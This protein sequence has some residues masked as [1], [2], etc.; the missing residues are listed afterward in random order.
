MYLNLKRSKRQTLYNVPVIF[1]SS[2]NSFNHTYQGASF[3]F[4]GELVRDLRAS[5][6][7][8][9]IKIQYTSLALRARLARLRGKLLL[10]KRRWD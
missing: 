4:S 5:R 3:D 10:A 6:S 7:G 9:N 8:R 1:G 2:T